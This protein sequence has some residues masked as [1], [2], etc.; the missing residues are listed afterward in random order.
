[1]AHSKCKKL[2]TMTYSGLSSHYEMIVQLDIRQHP[3]FFDQTNSRIHRLTFN[4]HN[5]QFNWRIEIPDPWK[6]ALISP[7]SKVTNPTELK[8]YRQIFVLPIRSKCTK[9]RFHQIRE[10]IKHSKFRRNTNL[11]I[12]KTTQ[13]QLSSQHYMT[14]SKWLWNKVSL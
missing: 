6:I 8:D 9:N 2:H 5:Q 12:A 11:V 10:F 7:I 13:W 3:S 1:M 14:T 4:I